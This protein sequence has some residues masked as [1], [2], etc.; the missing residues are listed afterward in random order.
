MMVAPKVLLFLQ[1][2]WNGGRGLHNRMCKWNTLFIE[3]RT[4]T[5]RGEGVNVS[6]CVSGAH[7]HF[8]QRWLVGGGLSEVL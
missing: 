1:H 7:E 8:Q 6:L 2:Y 5:V 3:T 4:T